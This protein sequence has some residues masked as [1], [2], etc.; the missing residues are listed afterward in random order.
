MKE[1][2]CACRCG[3]LIIFKRHHRWKPARYISG[4][5]KQS[6]PTTGILKQCKATNNGYAYAIREKKRIY[7][8]RLVMEIYLKRR[9]KK[10]EIVHHVNGNKLDNRIENLEIVTRGKHMHLHPKQRNKKGQFI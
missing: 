2:L 7:M 5:N 9:L 1:K 6:N 10:N 8:H 4:H 3:K